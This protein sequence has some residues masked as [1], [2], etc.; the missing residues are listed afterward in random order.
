[1]QCL[2]VLL[3]VVND[4]NDKGGWFRCFYFCSKQN[5]SIM[6]GIIHLKYSTA[7]FI[8]AL[9]YLLPALTMA[10]GTFQ[11]NGNGGQADLGNNCYRLTTATNNQFGSAWYKQKID[12]NQDFDMSA[13][14]NFGTQDGGADGIVFAFQ[15]YCTSAGVGGGGIGILNVTP[16]VFV[17]FDTWQN[18]NYND[19]AYDHVAIAKNGDVTHGTANALAAPVGIL[20]GNPNVENGQ[21]YLV[22]IL[23]TIADT[24]LKV[25]VN[26]NLR[27]TYSG[28][29][30]NS[31]F[32]GSPYVYWGFTAATGGANNLHTFCI[33]TPPTNIIRLNNIEICEGSSQQVSL[34]GASSYAWSPNT[35]ISSTTVSNPVLSPTVTTTYTV[36][37]TDACN[38]VQTDTIRVTVNPL[39]NVSLNLPFVQ[40]CLGGAS[41]TLSGGTPAGGT[42]SG[43]GVSA[44]QFN[45][46]TAGQ[47]AH[48]IDYTYTDANGCVNTDNNIV[49]VN[50]LPNVSLSSFTAVCANDPAFALTGGSP[51]GGTYSGPGVS[52]GNFNPATAGNGTHTISY[53]Y[54]D[55]NTGCTGSDSKTITVNS[56][57]AA[58]INTPGGT[59]LCSGASINLTTNAVGGVS[60]QWLQNASPVTNSAPG[61]TSYTVASQGAYTL[62][63]TS[64][65]G[66]TA[67]S[68]AVNVT[69]GVTPTASIS[70]GSTQFCPGSSVTLT[71]NL[72]A[73]ETIAWY[74]NNNVIN[75]ATASTY[76]ATAAGSYTAIITASSGCTATSNAITL[77]QLPGAVATATSSLPA[78][79][80]NT[81][82]ITLTAGNVNGA[83]YQWLNGNTPIN[84]ATSATYSAT[85]AGTYSVIVSLGTCADTSTAITLNTAANPTAILTTADSSYCPGTGSLTVTQTNGASYSWFLNGSATAGSN[86]SLSVSQSG[87]YYAVV[88]SADQCSATSNTIN[89]TEQS[90][91]SAVISASSTTICS[92]NAVTLTA[93]PVATATYEW[94]RNGTSQGAASATNT[95]SATQSGSYTCIVSNGC[96]STSNAISVTVSTAPPTPTFMFG[97]T[98]VCL[99][100]FDLFSVTTVAG[101]TSYTWSVSPAGAGFVQSGQGTDEVTITFL[102]QNATVSAVA[103]N[104]CGSSSPIQ[105]SVTIDNNPFCGG[106]DV[107]FGAAPTNTCQGSTVTFYNYTDPTI[108]A[109]L[110][111]VWDFGAG[112]TPAT[113]TSSGPVT[114]TYNSPGFKTVT[115]VYNDGFGNMVTGIGYTDYINIS[116]SV[117]TSAISGNAN[118]ADC[119]N[120]TETYSVT[121]TAGS[122]YNWTVTGGTI[123][124]GQGT[125]SATVNFPTSGGVV[126]VSETNSA[127]CVGA[128]VT[129]NVSCPDGVVNTSP[130]FTSLNVYP[131][132]SNGMLTLACNLQ[133]SS[134]YSLTLFD[135]AGKQIWNKNANAAGGE[136]KEQLD[137]TGFA[138]A[139]YFMQISVE[140]Q[141]ATKKIVLQ[142]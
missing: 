89:M 126:S 102:N 37:M 128:A 17:E 125:N 136:F 93:D 3:Y 26:G 86:N 35:G 29:I 41:V 68:S 1:L 43:P 78:F 73:N 120:N 32:G 111:P 113:S 94:F 10:Q 90:A 74:L 83:N 76:N 134:A 127:G 33:V 135:I 95:F 64:G 104:A 109:A 52:G 69:S 11:L 54:I 34:P 129:F 28:N 99:G 77:T 133:Q 106:N 31:V 132:P 20:A 82:S 19:P 100:G 44:G 60:Y 22:R 88:V 51:L 115:L 81:T 71:S 59:V 87:A 84:T 141:T 45:P 98:S 116:G 114:V 66:C 49:L 4:A 72:G 16:S 140:G 63:A 61:N 21:D 123:T 122:T 101:A 6:K 40:Q 91:P 138:K 130:L 38:N 118:L 85:A 67:T 9:L 121:N 65:A 14:L 30:V 70:S 103:N 15:N 5:A 96:S 12:L 27:Q 124:S 142:D 36:S 47:G 92:G 48:Q 110:L 7:I 137:F 117:S 79:C 39:P 24:T 42:Y 18:G 58:T 8:T 57:P 62:I 46:T 50:P 112:A 131:N 108:V 107:F 139:V 97:P 23:W 13:N 25:Y 75:N 56:V 80:P 105:E 55:P 53:N 2:Y 119:T